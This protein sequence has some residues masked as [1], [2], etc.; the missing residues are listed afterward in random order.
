[1]AQKNAT[2]NKAQA[3]VLKNHKMNPLCWVVTQEHK[4]AL[5]VMHRVTKEFRCIAK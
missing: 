5:I 2:P 4:H 1:M 3:T